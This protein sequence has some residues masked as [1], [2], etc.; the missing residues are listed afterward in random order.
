MYK[1]HVCMHAMHAR[2]HLL[3][4]THCIGFSSLSTIYFLFVIFQVAHSVRYFTTRAHDQRESERRSTSWQFW[5]EK[6]TNKK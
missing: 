6:K 3:C 5:E 1:M 4:L 2:T